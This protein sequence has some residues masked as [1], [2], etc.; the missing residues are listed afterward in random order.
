MALSNEINRKL[1]EERKMNKD[2]EQKAAV[3]ARMRM[4]REYQELKKAEELKKEQKRL[5]MRDMKLTYDRQIQ[6]QKTRDE[7]N[8]LNDTEFSLNKVRTF[9]V[10]VLYN[11]L[12]RSSRNSH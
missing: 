3:E 7:S 2:A 10:L 4:E 8:K 6:D 12:S 9:F 1:L 11:T 5:E